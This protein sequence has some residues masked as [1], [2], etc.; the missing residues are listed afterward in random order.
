MDIMHELQFNATKHEE[1]TLGNYAVFLTLQ[2]S[3]PNS[4]FSW[5]FRMGARDDYFFEIFTHTQTLPT[6]HLHTSQK[7][8]KICSSQGRPRSANLSIL[9]NK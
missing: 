2:L 7:D 9:R 8:S 4:G 3:P 1:R 6:V 5:F